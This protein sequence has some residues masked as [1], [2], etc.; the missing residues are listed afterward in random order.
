M[1]VRRAGAEE[2][3]DLPSKV[4]G[5][6]MKSGDVVRLETAGGGG[7]GDPGERDEKSRA[8]DFAEGYVDSNLEPLARYMVKR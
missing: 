8:D 7:F 1:I 2:E 3:Y 6:A 4:A 5:L